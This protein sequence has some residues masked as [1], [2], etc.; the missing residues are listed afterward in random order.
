MPCVFFGKRDQDDR[1]HD[2]QEEE[3]VEQIVLRFCFFFEAAW[4]TLA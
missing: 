1:D 3:E 4:L 2:S